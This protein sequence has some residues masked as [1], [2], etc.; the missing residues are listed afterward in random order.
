MNAQKRTFS[1]NITASSVFAYDSDP[2]EDLWPS[3]N[4]G[5]HLCEMEKAF[6]CGICKGLMC[7]PQSLPCHHSYCSE[8]I[9]KSTDKV[10]W[11][12]A[13]NKCPL[14]GMDCVPKQFI[15]NVSLGVAI[16]AFKLARMDLL[17]FLHRKPPEPQI[18]Q[19]DEQVPTKSAPE[20]AHQRHGESLD[21]RSSARKRKPL[22]SALQDFDPDQDSG[23]MGSSTGG[24]L[25]GGNGTGRIPDYDSDDM[26]YPSAKREPPRR[27]NIGLS[28]EAE[29]LPKAISVQ[30][31]GSGIEITKR[32]TPYN[33][34]MQGS[35][36]RSKVLKELQSLTAGSRVRPRLDGDEDKLK[37]RYRAIV[38]RI[39]AQVGSV[40]AL[41]LDEVVSTCN[42]AETAAEKSARSEVS[43]RRNLDEMSGNDAGFQKLIAEARRKQREAKVSDKKNTLSSESGRFDPKSTQGELETE[44]TSLSLPLPG[45]Q[46]IGTHSAE[47]GAQVD[48]ET[49]TPPMTCVTTVD[50]WQVLYSE[51]A[52]RNFYVNLNTGQAQFTVPEAFLSSASATENADTSIREH[53]SHA[54]RDTFSGSAQGR[55]PL[56]NAVDLDDGKC[57]EPES[58]SSQSGAFAHTQIDALQWTCTA[59]TLVNASQRSNCE[60]CQTP[61]P[62]TLRKKTRSSSGSSSNSG[63]MN[64]EAFRGFIKN[65]VVS[66][67]AG[68]TISFSQSQKGG[69]VSKT[70][71]KGRP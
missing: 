63:M 36:G 42:A 2:D 70:S 35:G 69:S 32:V 39:N 31:R 60:V 66:A 17:G 67:A 5:K 22:H 50:N 52:Q 29:E 20:P 15:P 26:E 10:L 55:A 18:V 64:M 57:G 61:N 1:S 4:L 46:G 14:C 48:E 68:G 25:R 44:P 3:T 54:A 27:T 65:P 19:R 58:C 51:K 49:D 7:N 45:E 24:R 34:N 43:S 23:D 11:M 13:Q 28:Y 21:L 59:C 53:F 47:G 41:T 30:A 62:A 6:T 8:C 16:K 71:K 12:N 37:V 40:D 9:S 33:F 56:E 38:H